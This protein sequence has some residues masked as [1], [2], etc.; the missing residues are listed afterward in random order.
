M[1]SEISEYILVLDY[2]GKILFCN[3][4]FLNRLKYNNG[5]L[6]NSSI[7][8]I[9][10]RENDSIYDILNEFEEIN[11]FLEFRSKSNEL[12]GI[13][14]RISIESFNNNKCIL[15]IGKEVYNTKNNNDFISKTK[16]E[17]LFKN[18]NET[19]KES[20]INYNKNVNIDL[21]KKLMHMGE[22]ILNYTQAHGLCIFL[23]SDAK[24]GLVPAVKLNYSN[25][26][27]KNIEFIPC[28]K[29]DM[30]SD[31]YRA[32]LNCT[33]LR[34]NIPNLSDIDYN[35][36]DKLEYSSNYVIELS[37]E[38][39]GIIT[40]SYNK[41][42]FP[43]SDNHEYMKYIS[44]K[45]AMVIENT[46][47]SK[48]VFIENK[49]RKYTEKE[50]ENYLNVS[51]DLVAIVGKDGYFKKV[52]PNWI[53][54]LGWT[55]EELLSMAIEDIVHPEEMESFRKGKKPKD[56]NGKITRNIIRFRHKNNNYIYLEWN[57]MYCKDDDIYIT[58]CRDITKN[59]EIEK[60]K[61]ELEQAV[62]LETIKNEF[63]ANISHE[64]RTPINIILGTMQV[65]NINVEKN[66]LDK[67]NL[68][69]YI[70]YIKQNSYRLL[71]L[72][73]NLIDIS[74]MDIGSY[75]LQCSNQ[76]IVSIIED[77]TLSVADYI[78]NNNIELIFD[79]DSEEVITYCD[80]DKIERIMLNLLSNAIKYT[81]EN[82]YIKVEIN[83]TKS[84]VIVSVKDSGVGIPKDKLDIIFDRFGQVN[85]SFNRKNE[86][87]GIG[88]SI[89]KNLVEMH[90]GY[91]DVKS[92]M[93]KGS[94]FI[95]TIPIKIR[96]EN[97]YKKS[98]LDR[99]Y[100]HVERCDIEFSDIYD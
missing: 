45:I 19:I 47:L 38:F 55:E 16:S 15:I 1:Y 94:D 43:K 29:V 76:N 21:N 87:S 5:E 2:K 35:G 13:K 12:V 86:G 77:I 34:D 18:Y 52:S 93:E 85:A 54:V 17:E 32:Y 51:V 7:S 89:V 82:G 31:K 42:S 30:N 14:A 98:D 78:K 71:R 59:I 95:F 60:E 33:Y 41:G 48:Q 100:K 6:L 58:T 74:K 81:K 56:I 70:K 24:E 3:N 72:A 8:N 83:T 4:N 97:N 36:L 62:E 99:K 22:Q 80:A 39:F 11:E 88:L 79:T 65:I 92:E 63:F 75:N 53:N 73:N 23:Y 91:I 57:S 44:N 9:I 69:K 40:L 37:D 46:R 50:L 20:D 28:K 10:Y 66:N 64:F 67:E 68:K 25:L 96:E 27:L 90:G 61:K 84:D 49:K 26:Y